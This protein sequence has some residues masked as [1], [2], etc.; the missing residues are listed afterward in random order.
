MDAT[1]EKAGRMMNELKENADRLR[2]SGV[3]L[4]LNNRI[5]DGI[6][7]LTQAINHDPEN[8]EYHLQRGVLFKRRKDFNSAIDDFLLGIDKLNKSCCNKPPPTPA[9]IEQTT[10]TTNTTT[11]GVVASE[12][13]PT[14]MNE[15]QKQLM[16]NFKRQVLL[17]YNDFSIQCYE[18]GYYDDAIVLLDK[19]IKT[20]KNEK[21]FYVN[22][23]GFY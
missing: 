4:G 15:Q 11:G 18:K 17:T 13:S 23:G 12:S 16:E 10:D 21:G 20:E 8:A 6:I 3:I 19:A 2:N 5:I 14:A 22:R 7:Q 9:A 1:N